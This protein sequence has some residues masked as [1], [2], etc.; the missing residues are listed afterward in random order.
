M[1]QNGP[2]MG[3][4]NILYGMQVPGIYKVRYIGQTTLSSAAVSPCKLCT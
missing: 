2:I 3:D 1:L 4:M